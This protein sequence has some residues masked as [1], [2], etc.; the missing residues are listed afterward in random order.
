VRVVD[1]TPLGPTR[2]SYVASRAKIATAKPAVPFAQR[3]VVARL[4]PAV[5]HSA[6]YTNDSR[7][8]NEHPS[9]QPSNETRSVNSAS[10]S[11]T[12][13]AHQGFR[14]FTPP[15]GTNTS[16]KS[17]PQRSSP[18]PPVRYTP[19]PKARDEMYDVHPPLNQ[20]QKPPQPA[21]PKEES[22]KKE[23]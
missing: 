21:K 8:F 17:E 2:S 6:V 23:K 7:P 18:N 13:D 9:A 20:N 19:A 1:T 12:Q 4:A 3:P 15:N 5:S 14:P 22:I 16:N 10:G 11:S